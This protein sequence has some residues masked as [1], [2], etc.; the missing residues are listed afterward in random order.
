[1][2]QSKHQ[3]NLTIFLFT[4][5]LILLLWLILFKFQ[6]NFKDLPHI[7]H[8]NLIPFSESLVINGKIALDEII[9][10]ILVFIPL[11]IYTCIFQSNRFLFQKILGCFIL[12]FALETLQFLFAIGASDITDLIGNT[13]GGSIGIFIYTLLHKFLKDKTISIIN[14]TA[15]LILI[16]FITLLT[17]LLL[18]NT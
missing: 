2:F 10:N 13:L 14:I 11:G 17:I 1:M 7:R 12:S 5:Y 9:Y 18:A 16:P 8:I 15:L 3:K 4:L 6:I